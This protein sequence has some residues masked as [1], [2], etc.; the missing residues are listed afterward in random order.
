MTER[1]SVRPVLNPA[2][3][4]AVDRRVLTLNLALVRSG[5]KVILRVGDTLCV[6]GSDGRPESIHCGGFPDDCEDI[7]VAE[8]HWN[9]PVQIV[10]QASHPLHIPELQGVRDVL[11][12]AGH[13]AAL[14]E[15]LQHQSAFWLNNLLRTLRPTGAAARRAALALV[16]EEAAARALVGDDDVATRVVIVSEDAAF[17]AT[18]A[19]AAHGALQDTAH[20]TV[21]LFGVGR[22][23][24]AKQVAAAVGSLVHRLSKRTR[25][26]D[27][28][29]ELPVSGPESR[30][31][32]LYW[33]SMSS[34]SRAAL[35]KRLLTPYELFV[36]P[37]AGEVPVGW[38][39]FGPFACRGEIWGSGES[40]SV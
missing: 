24:G 26:D 11:K 15:N 19:V 10:S 39:P 34:E 18:A 23:A 14:P 5:E 30:T 4:V 22:N 27:L 9:A 35:E 40:P 33:G 28:A 37:I 29:G 13:S 7:K 8:R 36:V 6:F 3:P 12:Q 31:L 16:S 2:F 21:D 17:A 20:I 25:V 1:W 32:L 38:I